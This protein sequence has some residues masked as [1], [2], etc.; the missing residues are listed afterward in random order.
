MNFS[1]GKLKAKAYLNWKKIEK[2]NRSK[3][4][5]PLISKKEFLKL[6]KTFKKNQK[7]SSKYDAYDFLFYEKI[8]DEIEF[9]PKLARIHMMK[10][11]SLYP[12][13][14]FRN[15]IYLLLGKSELKLKNYGGALNFFHVVYNNSKDSI[16]KKEVSK[17]MAIIY[18]KLYDYENS[19]LYFEKSN[20][21][22]LVIAILNQ[23]LKRF[24]KSL[25]IIKKIFKK[26]NVKYYKTSNE[27]LKNIE[28]ISPMIEKTD[29]FEIHCMDKVG[30]K[31]ITRGIKS[32]KKR[33]Y[34]FATIY[35][36][37]ALL[38]N[39]Y[40]DGAKLG[41][42]VTFLLRKKYDEA[43]IDIETL[44]SKNEDSM[45]LKKI[46]LLLAIK[47]KNI[48]QRIKTMMK[49]LSKSGKIKINE[50]NNMRKW[51]IIN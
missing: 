10:F 43:F 6:K 22:D 36:N 40:N 37:K 3:F 4:N 9:N 35:F 48:E 19:L 7:I 30:Q 23:K 27:L 2:I 25:Q 5:F 18:Y 24:D 15:K 41:R 34:K 1:E 32:L 26:R 8:I 16:V 44:I 14:K 46:F 45:E 42:G 31:Y 51:G 29:L 38:R 39:S 13:S 28:N 11:I 17:T 20:T 33:N 49:I 47:T 21:T 50:I 12:N